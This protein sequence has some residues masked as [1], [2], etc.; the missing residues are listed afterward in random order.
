MQ[1]QTPL[2]TPRYGYGRMITLQM[3]RKRSAS[4]LEDRVPGHTWGG[5]GYLPAPTRVAGT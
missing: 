5:A 2:L 3:Q 1:G 4:T